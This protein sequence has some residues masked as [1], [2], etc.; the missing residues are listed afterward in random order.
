VGEGLC[1]RWPQYP[2]AAP[3]CGRLGGRRAASAAR[4]TTAACLTV[5]GLRVIGAILTPFQGWT[6]FSP[7]EEQTREA[8]NHWIRTSNAY[9]GVIDFDTVIRDPADPLR[10]RPAYDSG[11]HLHP[12]DAGYMAMGAA[13]ILN[14]LGTTVPRG[15]PGLQVRSA[16]PGTA[17]AGQTVTI[18]GSGFGSSPGYVQFS[19]TGTYWG[20]PVND[21]ALRIDSWSEQAI[22]FTVPAP[23]GPD[24]QWHVTPGTTATI[25]VVN[26]AGAY[27]P[28]A[29]LGI[30]PTASLPDYYD[31]TGITTDTSQGCGNLDGDGFSLSQQALAAAGLVPGASV[32]SGGLSYAWPAA[33]A[34]SPDNVLAAAQTVLLQ[35]SR[36]DST[37][38]LLGTST[39][40]VSQGLILVNYSDGTSSSATVAFG[41]WAGAPVTGDVAVATMPYRNSQAGASQQLTVYVS[42]AQV[43]VNPAKRVVS[44]TLPE[45]GYS[46]AP[47][48]TAMHVFSLALGS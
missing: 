48:V 5:A 13:I 12:N 30:T 3:V 45:I 9:D 42:A 15:S 8:V 6:A 7:Q 25:N 36:G 37:M 2:A 14:G 24:G 39:S 34:C 40:G 1:S 32:T 4:P 10:M 23:S 47:S 46:V 44:V 31:D 21:A 29:T 33:T 16:V 19:D 41:D 17:S 22:T 38:G 35:G 20:S 28:G 26:A 43:P 11:D 27:S 18:R